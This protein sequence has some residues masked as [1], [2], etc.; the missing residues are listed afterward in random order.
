[1][2][3]FELGAL[4]FVAGCG[5]AMVLGTLAIIR[6]AGRPDQHDMSRMDYI[7]D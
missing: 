1:M 4:L 6:M 3:G 7:A 5:V 2:T